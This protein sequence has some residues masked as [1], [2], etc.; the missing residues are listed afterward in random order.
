MAHPRCDTSSAL[1]FKLPPD[2]VFIKPLVP[3]RAESGARGI[4]FPYGYIQPTYPTIEARA[5]WGPRLGPPSQG[6]SASPALLGC[7]CG[8]S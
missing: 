8:H 7:G 2:F 6:G 5:G 4:G 3:P 1:P